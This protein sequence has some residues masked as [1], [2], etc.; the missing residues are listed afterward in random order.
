[1]KQQKLIQ[2]YVKLSDSSLN[3]KAKTVV[4]SLTGNINFPVMTPTI[5]DFTITQTNFSNALEKATSGD[6]QLIALKNQA[7]DE[8]L[9]AMRQLAMDVDAQANGDKALLIS[10]G[11]DLGSSGDSGSVLG[12]PSDF[13]ISD[14]INAGE[15]KFSCKKAVN[16][17]SY[18]LEYTDELPTPDTQWKIQPSSTREL[19]VRGL[20]SGVRIYGRMKA[21]GRKGQE[22]NS[23]Q[24]SRVVQ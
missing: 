15:L 7:K 23:D 12:L 14:G 22:A 21:V 24:S 10:S 2:D 1:M 18:I 17:V 5:A 3:F 8:L 6:R 19:T 20:R 9:N 13:K 11:F 16:A 4:L